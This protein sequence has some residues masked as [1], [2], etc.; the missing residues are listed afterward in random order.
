[1][2]KDLCKKDSTALRAIVRENKKTF[3]YLPICEECKLCPEYQYNAPNLSYFF[4]G[5]RRVG[6]RK[7]EWGKWIEEKLETYLT[8]GHI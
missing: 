5:R 7:N 6:F 8:S 3:G 4:C 1:M 2:I